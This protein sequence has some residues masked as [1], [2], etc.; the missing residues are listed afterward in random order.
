MSQFNPIRTPSLYELTAEL[1]DALSA[2]TLDTETGEI[3]GMDRVDA[4][5]LDTKA[6]LENVGK[7]IKFL[8]RTAE[9]A[10]AEIE[11]MKRRRDMTK[12]IIDRLSVNATEAMRVLGEKKL[13]DDAQTV[14]L[15]VCAKPASVEVLDES[16]LP[17]KFVVV[18]QTT[19]I[20]KIGISRALKAGEDVP[21]ARLVTGETYLRVK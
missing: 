9:A 4:L 12:K 20:D 3:T 15:T 7:A 17:P 10:D 11:A 5:T 8:K 18:K 2:V 21:G 19:A 1:M 14:S 6:K 13:T 16:L